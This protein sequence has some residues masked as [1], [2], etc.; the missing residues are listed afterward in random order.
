MEWVAEG[1][2]T[3]HK[4]LELVAASLRNGKAEHV[5]YPWNMTVSDNL[6]YFIDI[7]S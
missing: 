3:R 7:R 5:T 1:W 6:N 2:Q 4:A